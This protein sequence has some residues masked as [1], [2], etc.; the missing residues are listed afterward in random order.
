MHFPLPLPQ[1]HK[2]FDSLRKDT[3]HNCRDG[4]IPNESFIS[5]FR[6][7]LQSPGGTLKALPMPKSYPVSVK[8]DHLEVEAK[9]FFKAPQA[10]PVCSQAWRTT[11]WLECG[12]MRTASDHLWDLGQVSFKP[13]LLMCKM[14]CVIKCSLRFRGS[15]QY[16]TLNSVILKSN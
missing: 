8:S 12:R 5:R 6:C 16:R 1:S 14:G 9:Q 10:I 13:W 11:A 15:F 4:S 7:T 3:R 2:P